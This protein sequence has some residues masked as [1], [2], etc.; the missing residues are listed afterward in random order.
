VRELLHL[1]TLQIVEGRCEVEQAR[2]IVIARVKANREKHAECERVRRHRES[3]LTRQVE[4]AK[5]QAA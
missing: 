1:L 3:F 2:A 5:V 4:L